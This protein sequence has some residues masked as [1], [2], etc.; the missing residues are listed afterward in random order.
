M[1]S[2]FNH[3]TAIPDALKTAALLSGKQRFHR[4]LDLLARNLRTGESILS[5]TP[6]IEKESAADKSPTPD[7]NGTSDEMERAG[8]APES[9]GR[10]ANDRTQLSAHGGARTSSHTNPAGHQNWG[11]FRRTDEH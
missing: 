3:T 4:F 8:K 1:R 2:F 6:S 9:D 10:G 7:G 5:D 11:L